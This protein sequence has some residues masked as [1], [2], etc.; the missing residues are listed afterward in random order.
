MSTLRGPWDRRQVS[1]YLS[2]SLIPLRL[3]ANMADG[4]PVVVSLWFLWDGTDLWCAMHESA[5]LV[6]HLRR[7]E[8]VAFEVAGDQ[9]PYRGVR[10]QARAAISAARDGHGLLTELLTRSGRPL[11]LLSAAPDS[12]RF[13]RR[14]RALGDKL[15]STFLLIGQVKK[16]F[17]LVS[18]KVV[19]KKFSKKKKCS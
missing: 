12:P 7:D 3:A 6:A 1:S 9:P 16:T 2:E 13:P 19:S 15:S 4:F 11:T 5:R 18:I 17:C 8:R 10:G 14:I